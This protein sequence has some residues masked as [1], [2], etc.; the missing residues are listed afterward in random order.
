MGIL[1]DKK[2]YTLNFRE[3][4]PTM[5]RIKP[6]KLPHVSFE[7][8]LDEISHSCGVGRAQ[9]K[10]SVEGLLDHTTLFMEYGMPVQLGDFG[11][12]KPTI[13][14]RSQHNPEDLGADNVVRKKILFYPG[15]RF[16]I[17]LS[18]MSVTAYDSAKTLSDESNDDDE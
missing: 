1:Y 5:Y 6:I 9:V 12:F 17:M 13:N 10:A 8:L 7:R 14:V 11:T 3:D 16:K 15:K 18:D 4:K 2:E